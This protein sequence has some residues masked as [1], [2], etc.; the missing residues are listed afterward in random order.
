L[1]RELG[2]PLFDRSPRRVT[3]TGAGHDL[4]A[5]AKVVLAAVDGLEQRAHELTVGV[6]PD[7]IGRAFEAAGVTGWLHAVD[8]DSGSEVDFGADETVT[9]GSV[10]KVPLLVALH[11]AA[12]AGQLDLDEPVTVTTDRTP[13]SAGLGAMQ[14]DARLS[15]R[16]LALLMITISDNAAAD[17]VLE[18][19][20]LDELQRTIRDLHLLHTDVMASSGAITQVLAKDLARDGRPSTAA[21]ADR[22]AVSA[23]GVLDP[24][25]TN[26][27]TPRDM[28]TLLG[29][30]WRDTAAG[31]GACNDMR[32]MLRLQLF[33][34]RI[35]SG[36]PSDDVVVAGKTGTL[37]SM[38]NEIAVVEMPDERRYALAIFTRSLR[39]AGKDPA[40]DAVIGT[41]ARLAVEQLRAT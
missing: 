34:H 13:G 16:D 39:A 22:A 11:R 25:R 5:E 12:D 10:F 9:L 19:L 28:T 18:R 30:I 23:F 33:R 4:L 32:R 27:S 40:A 37:P 24:G 29:E 21:L 6:E 41:A 38:R 36:F 20:G 1:E 8:I 35:A 7:P 2:V 17:A 3:L 15:L 31:P 26:R 14:D